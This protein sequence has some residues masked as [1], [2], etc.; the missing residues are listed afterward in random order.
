MAYDMSKFQT[1]ESATEW[2]KAWAKRKFGSGIESATAEILNIYGRLV[3]R[4]KYET[5]SMEPFAYSTLKYD[6]ATNVLQ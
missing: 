4:R 6:E 3:L 1:A 2:L 5:L